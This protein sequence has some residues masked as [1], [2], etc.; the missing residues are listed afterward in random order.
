MWSISNG[1]TLVVG[2]TDVTPQSRPETW[3]ASRL[4]LSI[5]DVHS[6]RD[7]RFDVFH[8]ALYHLFCWRSHRTISG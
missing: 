3:K 1:S 7:C 6:S 8:S 2:R 5:V 4:S